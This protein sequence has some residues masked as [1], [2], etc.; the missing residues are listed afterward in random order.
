MK[1]GS[2]V[3]HI[4]C[5]SLCLAFPYLLLFSGCSRP[6]P[7]PT[8]PGEIG[9]NLAAL[10]DYSTELVFVDLFKQ[11]RPWI[12]EKN[13]ASFGSLPPVDVDSFG[14]LVRLREGEIATAMMGTQNG[15]PSGQYV[16]L[17]DGV[18]VVDFSGNA[19]VLNESPGRLVVSVSS[20][21]PISLHVKESDKL[22]PIKNIRFIMPGFEDTHEQKPFY[23]PFV[24]RTA[25]FRVVRF[26]DWMNTNNCPIRFWPENA[27]CGS[28]VQDCG[29]A[30]DY[31]IHL[32]NLTD[33]HPWFCIPHLAMD[34]YVKEFAEQIKRDLSPD[35]KVYVEHSNEVWNGQFSQA[36]YASTRGINQGLS[37]H[38]YEAGILYHAKRSYEIFGIWRQVLGRDRVV[39]VLGS[40]ARTPW[41]SE[42]LAEFDT[43]ENRADVLA[44]APYFGGRIGDPEKTPIESLTLDKVFAL[45]EKEIEKVSKEVREHR[46]IAYENSMRVIAYESGQHL[47]GIGAAKSNERLTE[48]LQSANRD[49]RMESMYL[50][51]KRSWDN[52]GGELFLLYNSVGAPSKWGSWGL[53]EDESQDPNSAPKYRAARALL[54]SG[55]PNS[56][57]GNAP[58]KQLQ[59]ASPSI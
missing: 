58:S 53:L 14:N 15:F 11:S 40:Q 33:T 4:R 18:G 45:C 22:D 44:I 50:L 34:S 37:R 12:A 20:G 46:Q 9:I 47:V 35:L 13:G 41:A 26:M 59:D 3:L 28:Q 38:R 1:F 49:D 27:A 31:M 25:Q 19:K 5:A 2:D 48:L 51:S 24:E 42:L 6:T 56:P 43:S 7:P 36:T 21:G 17:Y 39:C 57:V 32:C 55:R 16:C 23:P 29:V 8:K 10:T 52:S 30:P 54:S